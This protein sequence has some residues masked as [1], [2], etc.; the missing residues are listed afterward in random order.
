V[1]TN[2]PAARSSTP[3]PEAALAARMASAGLAEARLIRAD[4]RRLPLHELIPEPGEAGIAVDDK[5]NPFA[6]PVMADHYL[7]PP[8]DVV[9]LTI[10]GRSSWEQHAAYAA[11]RTLRV[12]SQIGAGELPDLAVVGN[13][14]G[15]SYGERAETIRACLLGKRPFAAVSPIDKVARFL[16]I[17]SEDS[18]ASAAIVARNLHHVAI[19]VAAASTVVVGTHHVALIQ[20][21]DG[22][23]IPVADLP[24]LP[25]LPASVAAPDGTPGRGGLNG[26]LFAEWGN[27]I[28]LNGVVLGGVEAAYQPACW[29]CDGAAAYIA[30]AVG[31][32]TVRAFTG[33]L[34]THPYQI[35][36]LVI[37]ALRKGDKLPA[38]IAARDELSAHRLL[39]DLRRRG[40]A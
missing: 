11:A 20:R 6:T 28:M 12:V 32:T 17:D 14:D 15:L 29:P 9:P 27:A 18:Y 8:G 23:W 1:A 10:P 37:N 25:V 4:L 31:R 34:L 36:A 13:G 21:D 16:S 26:T 40:I 22:A 2:T 35:Q 33:R 19:A 38:L 24:G 39:K 3:C 30:A 7:R 5:P